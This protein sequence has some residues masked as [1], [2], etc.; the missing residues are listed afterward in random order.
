[1]TLVRLLNLKQFLLSHLRRMNQE[2]LELVCFPLL[3]LAPLFYFYFYFYFYFIYNS[4][5]VSLAQKKHGMPYP[6]QFQSEFAW[7]IVQLEKI[8]VALEPAMVSLKERI[9]G[10]SER[11]SAVIGL[12][13]F[14]E[15]LGEDP[16]TQARE[17][18]DNL[19]RRFKSSG[20]VCSLLCCCD[21]IF[22][23]GT[24]P[25]RLHDSPRTP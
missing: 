25:P 20:A 5:S 22:F 18:V 13:D 21:C 3:P 6:E 15:W 4:L 2:A 8:R 17:I 23:F 24:D 7:L 19:V 12:D 10:L 9:S 11:K 14:E 1:M 16:N